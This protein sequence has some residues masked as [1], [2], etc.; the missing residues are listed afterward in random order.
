MPRSD[1]GRIEYGNPSSRSPAQQFHYY[2]MILVKILPL[3]LLPF[4]LPLLKRYY[5]FFRQRAAGPRPWHSIAPTACCSRNTRRIISRLIPGQDC[6]NLRTVKS[7][8]NLLIA[9]TIKSVLEP[10]GAIVSPTF[11]KLDPD[12]LD[13]PQI[14]PLICLPAP[15]G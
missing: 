1:V 10:R 6:S 13:I 3:R 2:L 12:D 14:A 8:S 4:L 9:A 15:C 11:C 7:P 5:P